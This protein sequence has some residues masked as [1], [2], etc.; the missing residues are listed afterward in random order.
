[1]SGKEAAAYVVQRSQELCC[2][3]IHKEANKRRFR[4][5]AR[6]QESC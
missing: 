6:Y 1:M 2:A 5:A 3:K 4:Q